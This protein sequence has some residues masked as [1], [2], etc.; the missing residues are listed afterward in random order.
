M[1][2]GTRAQTRKRK[3]AP[4][5]ERDTEHRDKPTSRKRV[6]RIEKADPIPWEVFYMSVAELEAQR[7]NCLDNEKVIHV[8]D[9]K[10]NSYYY[11]Y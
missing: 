9:N 6:K 1:A 10:I 11:G 4:D 3:S 5:Q 7:S 8:G 2:T